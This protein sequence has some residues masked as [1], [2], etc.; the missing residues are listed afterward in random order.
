VKLQGRSDATGAQIDVDGVA[1][2]SVQSN[3]DFLADVAPGTH[4]VR[5]RMPGYL[6]AQKASVVVESEQT[7]TLSAVQLRG[8]DVNNDNKVGLLD[9]VTVAAAY[10][11]EPPAD[12]RGD[13]NNDGR[14]N[15]FDLVLVAGNY[16][17]E[18]PTEWP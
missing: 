1:A 16:W 10:N 14:I 18:G 9:L 6:P 5:A 15:L 3:G 13:I 17:L 8:G 2:G 7:T 11:T 4:Q 12:P